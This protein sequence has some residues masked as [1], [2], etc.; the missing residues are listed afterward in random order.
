MGYLSCLIDFEI[1]F[2]EY[3]VN[4]FKY[5]FHSNQSNYVTK[6]T[7]MNL[8]NFIG[9]IAGILS[10]IAFIPQV[11]KI[12][13]NRSA[14]DISKGSFTMFAISSFLWIV[15]GIFKLEYPLILANLVNF[16]L[17]CTVLLLTYKYKSEK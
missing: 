1:L 16:T 5:D 12:W 3:L 2:D 6:E 7:N 10:T 11:I 13:R 14:Q 15:Y 4:K 8:I 17:N 9:T